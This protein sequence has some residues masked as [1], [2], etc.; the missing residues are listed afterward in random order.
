MTK[1]S[2]ISNSKP[3]PL[4]VEGVFMHNLPAKALEEKF[5]NIQESLRVDQ[6]GVLVS[7][8]T[9]LVCDEHGEPFEDCGTAEEILSAL[10]IKDIQDIL[11]AVTKA[12]VPNGDNEGK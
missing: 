1:L 8:F 10:S 6:E 3:I 7:I 9:G 5:G 2:K 11:H 12:L 4:A